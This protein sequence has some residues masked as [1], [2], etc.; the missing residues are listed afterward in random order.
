M[1]EK[2][3]LFDKQRKELLH[4]RKKNKEL[5]KEL[6]VFEDSV[7]NGSTL[8]KEMIRKIPDSSPEVPKP[9]RARVDVVDITEM[10]AAA[11]R[12]RALTEAV[13]FLKSSD[14]F[15]DDM[16]EKSRERTRV[17]REKVKQEEEATKAASVMTSAYS[18]LL[19]D[20]NAN[21]L[22]MMTKDE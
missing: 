17:L 18:Q 6:R 10:Q 2:E 9:K 14:D 1:K 13:T 5:E 12:E 15:L 7:M 21:L 20:T 11:D 19:R 4:E 3:F 8:P 22:V 16:L